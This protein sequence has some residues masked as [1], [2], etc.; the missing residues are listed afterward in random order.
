MVVRWF[1]IVR[2][3]RLGTVLRMPVVSWEEVLLERIA[4]HPARLIRDFASW[5]GRAGA[6]RQYIAFIR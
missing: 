5:I 6:V 3:G 1:E 4:I 2:W